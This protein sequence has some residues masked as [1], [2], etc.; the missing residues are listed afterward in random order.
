MEFIEYLDAGVVVGNLDVFGQVADAHHG[1][2]LDAFDE[3]AG[4]FGANGDH[5]FVKDEGRGLYDVRGVCLDGMLNVFVFAEVVLFVGHDEH[6]R[7]DAED[8]VSEFVFEAAGDAD[9]ADQGSDAQHDAEYRDDRDDGE[10]H[11]RAAKQISESS[12]VFKH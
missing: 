5:H 12:E 2:G 4:D 1:L 11:A 8:F 6:V 9:D 10:T 3:D 7:V